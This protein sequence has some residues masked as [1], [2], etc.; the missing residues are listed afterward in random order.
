MKLFCLTI[1]G[2]ASACSSLSGAPSLEGMPFWTAGADGYRH[3]TGDKE[4]GIQLH[5]LV[6]L[7]SPNVCIIKMP[8]ILVGADARSG[9]IASVCQSANTSTDRW[10]GPAPVTD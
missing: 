3:N 5:H 6:K 9:W 1:I 8:P 4:A 7:K 10:C 2:G